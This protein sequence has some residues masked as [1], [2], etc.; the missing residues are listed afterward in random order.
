MMGFLK[1]G[2]LVCCFVVCVDC[3]VLYVVCSTLELWKEDLK[4]VNEKAAESLADPVKYAN[5]FPDLQYALKV[6][7]Y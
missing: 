3:V 6:K 4:K 1:Y 5:L 7:K 2:S